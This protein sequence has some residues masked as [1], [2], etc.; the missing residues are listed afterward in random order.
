MRKYKIHAVQDGM[1]TGVEWQ[2]SLTDDS[3]GF[4][5]DSA[6]RQINELAGDQRG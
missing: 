2:P 6:T 1:E 5:A 3:R 4:A